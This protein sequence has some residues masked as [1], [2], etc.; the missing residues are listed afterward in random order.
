MEFGVAR[1]PRNKILRL[2]ALWG[3]LTGKRGKA[4]RVCIQNDALVEEPG[5][6]LTVRDILDGQVISDGH[7]AGIGD[8]L[9]NGVELVFEP[10]CS[11]ESEMASQLTEKERER[12]TQ[13]RERAYHNPHATSSDT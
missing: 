11:C 6:E 4:Y 3:N 2:L 7:V 1:G 8:G 13:N 9:A 10:H 5:P 12:Y